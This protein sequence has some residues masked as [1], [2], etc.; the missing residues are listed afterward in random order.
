MTKQE[1]RERAV[2]AAMDNRMAS[3]QLILWRLRRFSSVY[4]NLDFEISVLHAI[5]RKL[6]KQDMIEIAIHSRPQIYR[7]TNKGR[8]YLAGE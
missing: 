7:S 1:E 4:S 6:K 5:L 8:D 3:A 2:L